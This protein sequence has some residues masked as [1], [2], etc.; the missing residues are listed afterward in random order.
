MILE[1][2]KGVPEYV[3]LPVATNISVVS[4]PLSKYSARIESVSYRSRCTKKSIN[5]SDHQ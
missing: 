1:V 4:R 5:Y 3:L 2:I